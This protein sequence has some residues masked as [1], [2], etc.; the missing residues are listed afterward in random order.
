MNQLINP[1]N[2]GGSDD[3]E[4]SSGI[5]SPVTGAP[6][7]PYLTHFRQSVIT[8]VREL[9]QGFRRLFVQSDNLDTVSEIGL[10]D[11]T[12]A[13]SW[14]SGRMPAD[15]MPAILPVIDHRHVDGL[16]TGYPLPDG[17][18]PGPL[19]AVESELVSDPFTVSNGHLPSLPDY[20]VS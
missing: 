5:T 9:Q 19:S 16:P 20:P 10:A 12:L 2:D 11:T 1:V 18:F 17:N 15:T 6:A 3:G 8:S 14:L 7:W 13:T 4:I